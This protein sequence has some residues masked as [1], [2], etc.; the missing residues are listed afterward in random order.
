MT[1]DRFIEVNG[2]RLLVRVEGQG[3]PV[4]LV[5][6]GIA[7]LRMW[8][9]FAAS[10][11]TRHRIVRYDLRGFGRST[12]PEGL[13]SHVEDLRGLLDGLGIGRASLVGISYGGRIA[14]EFA[15]R[16]P[17]RV[18]RLVL[19]APGLGGFEWT[20]Q[21]LEY[22]RRSDDL[23]QK[24][25]LEGLVALD[26]ATWVAGPKRTLEEIE[27]AL[28]DRMAEMIR[29]ANA[30]WDEQSRGTAQWLDPPAANRLR[31]VR[32]PTLVVVGDAD[33]PDMIAI[34]DLIEKRVSGARK[35]VFAGVAHMLPLERPDPFEQLVADFLDQSDALPTV[36]GHR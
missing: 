8:D 20:K 36:Q 19:V 26:L 7:D 13:Y 22:G 14:M 31:A 5:H 33:L 25:D 23:A 16:Y 28:R 17:L 2:A 21:M 35:V 27:P 32:T 15:I 3:P 18:G 29:G 10:S 6:A 12:M 1:A 11:W 24:G 30:R 34:A 9:H 4:A